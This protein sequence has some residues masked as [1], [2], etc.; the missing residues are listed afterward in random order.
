VSNKINIK[1]T[2]DI[3]HWISNDKRKGDNRND[4][5]F[6]GLSWMQGA[7]FSNEAIEEQG[8]YKN[9]LFKEPMERR[10]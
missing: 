8:Y 6:R 5:L 7:G 1:E 2:R 3:L 9:S 10:K 4:D